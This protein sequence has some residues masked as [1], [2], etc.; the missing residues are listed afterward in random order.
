MVR[1]TRGVIHIRDRT[2][3]VAF[4]GEAYGFAEGEY[5]RFIAPFAKGPHE[6]SALGPAGHVGS[7]MQQAAQPGEQMSDGR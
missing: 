3:L 7:N 6:L 5:A 2:Q 4:A 1:S